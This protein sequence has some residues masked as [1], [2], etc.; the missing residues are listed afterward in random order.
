[1]LETNPQKFRL[2]PRTIIPQDLYVERAADRQL[3]SIVEEMGRPGYV[4]VARQMGKTNLLLNAKRKLGKDDATFCYLDVSNYIPDLRTFF[5][6]LIDTCVESDPS[7]FHHLAPEISNKRNESTETLPHKEHESELLKLLRATPGKLIICLDEIDALTKTD[8]SDQVFALIRSIYFSGRTNFPEFERLTYLLSGVAE[9]SDIIKNRAISPFNIGEK[10]YLEDFSQEETFQFIESAGLHPNVAVRERIFH[11]TN[12]NPRCTWDL[13]ASIER[14]EEEVTRADQVDEIV[15]RLYLTSFDLPPIDHIRTLA[16]GDRE[17]RQAIMSLGYGKWDAISDAVKSRLYLSGITSHATDGGIRIKNRIIEAALSPKWITE[18]D[19]SA[20]S[21]LD[22]ARKLYA[23]NNFASALEAFKAY[24]DTAATIPNLDVYCYEKGVCEYN[25]S[26]FGAA[27]ATFARAPLKRSYSSEAF[28]HQSLVSGLCLLMLGRPDEAVLN[29]RT[30]VEPSL[31]DT[32]APLPLAYYQALINLSSAILRSTDPSFAEAEAQCAEVIEAFKSRDDLPPDE[33]ALLAAHYNLYTLNLR[34][35]EKDV[36]EAQLDLATKYANLSSRIG[37]LVEKARRIHSGEKRI[38]L[39]CEAAT[40][41]IEGRVKFEKN[42]EILGFDEE[43]A[44]AIMVELVRGGAEGKAAVRRLVDYFNAPEF[45]APDAVAN[46]FL[47][48]LFYSGGGI[49]PALVE[50]TVPALVS[51]PRD[52]AAS[53][54]RRNVLTI[55]LLVARPE[56]VEVVGPAFLREVIGSDQF[57]GGAPEAR[58]LNRYVTRLMSEQKMDQAAEVI[59]SARS[60][61]DSISE[62]SDSSANDRTVFHAVLQTLSLEIS[63]PADVGAVMAAYSAA[64]KIETAEDT[65]VTEEF[66]GRLLQRLVRLAPKA[67]VPTP[68]HRNEPKVGRNQVVVVRWRD[69][70][71]T[72]GKMKKFTQAIA[73]GE[74]ELVSVI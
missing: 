47:L 10:I 68:V 28:R 61:L 19:E 44:S 45:G 74:A 31:Y 67:F 18:I 50:L 42:K 53:A 5:R 13:C 2:K 46:V 38:A 66:K 69:G 57:A 4:L 55:A 8:Y 22:L 70:T 41:C 6:N 62:Q 7:R 9:P 29:L 26:D 49:D 15:R 48:S 52:I 37:I 58:A 60:A 34:R 24:E 64:A 11:W 27:L 25:N 54:T 63:K 59:E 72:T 23:E 65:Y 36:A 32:D 40:L 39:L 56:E 3:E 20:F 71:Q 21:G 1:M 43:V 35:G 73:D 17:I 12:G 30:A 33:H 14:S 51:A 16:S